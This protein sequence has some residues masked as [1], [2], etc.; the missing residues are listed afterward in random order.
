MIFKG[1]IPDSFK[2]YILHRVK[3][4]GGKPSELAK[5]VVISVATIYRVQ[6]DGIEALKKKNKNISPGR[7]RKLS[8]RK[9]RLIIRQ[10]KFLRKE[11]PNFSYGSLFEACESEYNNK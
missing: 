6:K 2:A 11:N 1:Y 5:E 8:A 10:V 9:E 4:G 7:P 3:Y